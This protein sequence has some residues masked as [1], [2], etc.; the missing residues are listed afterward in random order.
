MFIK[1]EILTWSIIAGLSRGKKVYKDGLKEF[2]KENFKKFL[3]KEL[4]YRFGNNYL[5]A[6]SETHIANL[7]KF[8]E[9]ID[10][11]Y[12]PILQGG[13]IYFGRIQKIVNLYLKYRWICFDER[14]PIH[15]PI[16]SLVLKKLDLP[17]INWTAMTAGQYREILKKAEKNTGGI[18]K[19]AE[20]EMD[21]FNKN[22]ITYKV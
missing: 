12:A 18:E 3:R 1:F 9:D 13:K 22:N 6:D 2:E 17:H 14:M 10:A 20:W 5:P 21:L 19:I 11:K 16:D 8:K 4:R 7:N 15:C